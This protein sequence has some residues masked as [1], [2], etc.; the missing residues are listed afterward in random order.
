MDILF[1][2]I[3]NIFPLYILIA[4]GFIAGRYLNVNLPSMATIVIYIVGP[5][6]TFGSIAKMDMRLDYFYLPLVTMVISVLCG[7]LFYNAG[8]FFWKSNVANLIG[9]AA[10]S[11]NTGYFGLPIILALFGPEWAGIYLFM[12]VGL[13]VGDFGLGYYI[14][15]RGHA[16]VKQAF[17]KMSKL[18]LLHG[19]ILGLVWNFS[20]IGFG[21]VADNYLDYAYG[22]W[23]IVGMMLIG[24]AL[25]KQLRLEI[26]WRLIGWM[27]SAKFLVWP[28]LMGLAVALDIFFFGVLPSE[29]HQMM[30]IFSVVPLA[31]NLTA[32][33]ATLNLHPE[34]AAAAVLI[35]T[36]LALITVPAAVML[37]QALS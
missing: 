5:Y 32:F 27:F 26:D 19:A 33:S 29:V 10:T 30:M 17:I 20:G 16:S 35:S 37:V 9:Q 31:A 4:L 21:D 22:T 3:S 6:V 2:L 34:K 12:N 24:V 14:G 13:I 23:T 28:V 1:L 7:L 25:S 8:K 11:G 15:A 36:F 18:P